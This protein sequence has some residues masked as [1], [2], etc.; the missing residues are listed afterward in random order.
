VPS[1]VDIVNLALVKLGASRI[2]TMLD[3][4]KAA[5]SANAI[6]AMERDNELR[7]HLWNFAVAR[8]QLPALV[9]PPPF[10]FAVQYQLPNDYLWAIQVGD[11]YPG[12]PRTIGIVS[13]AFSGYKIEG[14]KVLTNLSFSGLVLPPNQTPGPL[15]L[16]YCRKIIDPTQFDP[17][18]VMA[19]AMRMAME[20][21]EDLTGQQNKRTMAEQEYKAAITTAIHANAI[22]LPPDPSPDHSWLNSRLPG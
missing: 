19:F 2:T 9:D 22:E 11:I 7:A 18:F 13:E 12:A 6:Y 8:I 17:C 21:A 5:R 20:L 10:G 16:R 15:N 4:V 3:N 14:G 1:D